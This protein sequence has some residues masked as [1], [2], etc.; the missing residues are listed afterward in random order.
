MGTNMHT[1]CLMNQVGIGSNEQDFA[2]SLHDI[3]LNIFLTN[4][5]K[6]KQCT[7]KFMSWQ[8]LRLRGWIVSS[9]SMPS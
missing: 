3:F 6:L 8:L 9:V 1:F 2:E 5:I 7:G 4:M